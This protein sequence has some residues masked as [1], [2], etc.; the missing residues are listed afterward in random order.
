MVMSVFLVLVESSFQEPEIEVEVE[1]E[2]LA[3]L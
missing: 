2:R 1:I 3:G